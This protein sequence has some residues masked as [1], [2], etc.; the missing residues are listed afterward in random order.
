[1]YYLFIYSFPLI[2]VAPCPYLSPPSIFIQSLRYINILRYYLVCQQKML[3][4]PSSNSIEKAVFQEYQDF[5]LYPVA[6]RGMQAS[7]LFDHLPCLP[8]QLVDVQT[9]T[10]TCTHS[11]SNTDRQ[12]EVDDPAES[13][14]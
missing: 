5:V 7:M 14:E 4:R 2:H 13:V 10:N 8:C 6:F 12:T 3:R 9:G 11:Q 1:M